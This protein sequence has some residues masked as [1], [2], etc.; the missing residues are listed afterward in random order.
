[1]TVVPAADDV[2]VV[3]QGMSLVLEELEDGG[4]AR[5]GVAHEDEP[6]AVENDG[7]R[8]EIAGS[9]VGQSPGDDDL[10]GREQGEG[11]QASAAESA[12]QTFAVQDPAAG[13]RVVEDG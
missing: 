1:M 9:S 11:V 13:V 4:L 10:I 6:R 8:M 5:L 7:T 3:A 12:L 2:A